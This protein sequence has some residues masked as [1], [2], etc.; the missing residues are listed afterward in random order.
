MMKRRLLISIFFSI[1][2]VHLFAQGSHNNRV[3]KN[4][5]DSLRELSASYF[6]YHRMWDDLDAP[7]PRGV[8]LKADYY[9]LYVPPTFYFAPLEQ[10][11]AIEWEPNDRLGMTACDSLSLA[12]GKQ[13]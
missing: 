12:K 10:A 11:Y 3:M 13:V 4:F 1:V 5:T 9:K 2:F 8:K 7:A 6:A